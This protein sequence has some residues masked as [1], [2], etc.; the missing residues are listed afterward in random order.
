MLDGVYEMLKH[1]SKAFC[2]KLGGLHML[3]HT[4]S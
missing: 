2:T 3:K 1:L 4:M